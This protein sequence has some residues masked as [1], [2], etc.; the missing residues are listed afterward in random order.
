VRGI[1]GIAAALVM[2]LPAA[3][4]ASAYVKTHGMVLDSVAT[5]VAA[6][7]LRGAA[8]NRPVVVVVPIPG[9]SMGLLGQRIIE[10]MRANGRDVRIRGRA[11]V[12]AETR[13]PT[14]PPG[15]EAAGSDSAAAYVPPTAELHA[16]V[17]GESVAFV[18]RIRSFPF[19]VKGYERLVSMRASATLIDPQSG[20]VF[21]ARSAA[22]TATDIVPPRD[23]AYVAGGSAGFHPAPPQGTGL[24]LLEPLIVI[25]VVAGLV[26]LFYSNRN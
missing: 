17:D 10:Q 5:M 16:R 25:G 1:V 8:M 13:S 12:P 21:W 14:L 26:V 19:G 2:L 18:R 23:L 15:Y 6:D 24:R 22:A 11:L 3:R 7:L 9:D 20:K 4:P